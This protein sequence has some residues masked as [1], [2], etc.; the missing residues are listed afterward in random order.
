MGAREQ[1]AGDPNWEE[2]WPPRWT[3][4][5]LSCGEDVRCALM[6]KPSEKEEA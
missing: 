1:D 2:R 4:V 6:V 3:S 5:D